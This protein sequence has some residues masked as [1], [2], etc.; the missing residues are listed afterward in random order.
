MS[1]LCQAMLN[2]VDSTIVVD[3]RRSAV[4]L[5]LS[6]VATPLP[7]MRLPVRRGLSCWAPLRTQPSSETLST[8]GRRWPT[9]RSHRG[10]HVNLHESGRWGSCS[11]GDARLPGNYGLMGPAQL[12]SPERSA[13]NIAGVRRTPRH[14]PCSA[15]QPEP[16]VS[17]QM[18]SPY[19]KG[20]F[21]RAISQC[22]VA[23]S[24]WALQTNPM[25]LTRKI[26]RRVGCLRSDEDEM[27]TCLKMSDPVGLT[28][29]GKIDVLLI[30]GKGVVMDLM[31]HAPVVDGDFI[32]DEPSRLSSYSTAHY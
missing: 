1:S 7:V 26:A 5:T 30:L 31:E 11:F 19:N 3:I 25:S 2:M 4:T 22:G 9:E 27:L 23:L 12:P 10:L 16:P 15:N 24:P 20:L 29:A 28:M 14:S 13:R 18:L 17:L 8:T 6:P 21:R 32:P